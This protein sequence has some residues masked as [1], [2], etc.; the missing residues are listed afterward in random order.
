MNLMDF[1]TVYSEVAGSSLKPEAEPSRGK[2]NPAKP[3]QTFGLRG[4]LAWPGFWESQ[5]R[6]S[7]PWL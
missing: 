6:W 1:Q 4:L 5:S 2:K 3:G 7:G